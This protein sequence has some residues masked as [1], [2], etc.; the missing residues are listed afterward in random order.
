MHRLIRASDS[1]PDHPHGAAA[2]PRKAATVGWRWPSLQGASEPEK[3]RPHATP[4]RF[5]QGL[6]VS[7]SVVANEHLA[8]LRGVDIP[9]RADVCVVFFG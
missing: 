3:E 4:W 5:W 1:S 6:Q 2:V 8:P 7:Y 9:D